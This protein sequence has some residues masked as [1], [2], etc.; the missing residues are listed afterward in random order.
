MSNCDK[1]KIRLF[2]PA[3]GGNTE[4]AGK[5]ARSFDVGDIH[6]DNSAYFVGL[7]HIETGQIAR[8]KAEMTVLYR[9]NRAVKG[10][11]PSRRALAMRIKEALRKLRRGR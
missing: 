7:H 2:L 11:A 10:N 3:A 5:W 6:D 9:H 1:A 4:L 8:G